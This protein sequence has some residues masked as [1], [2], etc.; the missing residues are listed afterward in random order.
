MSDLKQAFEETG[1]QLDR[2]IAAYRREKPS[3][4]ETIVW[5]NNDTLSSFSIEDE[6]GENSIPDKTNAVKVEIGMAVT[7]IGEFAFEGCS[8]LTLVTI[9]DS[10]KSIENYAFSGCSSLISIAIP[11]GVTSIGGSV[12]NECSGLTS[13]TIPDSV[14]SIGDDAFMNCSNLMLLTIPAGVTSIGLGAFSGCSGL[15]SVVIPDTVTSIG[16]RAF[17]GCS[18][19]SSITSLR[20]S[21]PTVAENTF[22][23]SDSTYTGRNTYSSGNNVLKVPTGA[24]GYNS[25]TWFDPLQS[26]TKCGFHIEYI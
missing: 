9:P 17:Y 3:H 15:T 2:I 12:F 8:N 10:V 25:G 5:Y 14:M 7:S 4:P 11:N 1:E 24:T 16:E 19:L 6:L 22:G 18:G 13:V 21:V 26:S 20:T 23:N